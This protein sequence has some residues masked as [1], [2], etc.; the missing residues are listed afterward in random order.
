MV[1]PSPC[2]RTW[3]AEGGAATLMQDSGA[4]FPFDYESEGICPVWFK[5]TSAAIDG[6]R[7]DWIQA[8]DISSI[9]HSGWSHVLH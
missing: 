9:R 7:L 8:C 1:R 3:I 2:A 5:D 4:E 6:R